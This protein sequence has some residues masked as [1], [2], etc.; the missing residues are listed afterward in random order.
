M[1]RPNACAQ[2]HLPACAKSHCVWGF[3]A[4]TQTLERL[5]RAQMD[6]G[7]HL[8]KLKAIRERQVKAIAS[9]KTCTGSIFKAEDALDAHKPLHLNITGREIDQGK[10]SRG[11]LA[12]TKQ[13][14]KVASTASACNVTRPSNVPVSAMTQNTAAD[15]RPHVTNAVAAAE[16]ATSQAKKLA[17]MAQRSDLSRSRSVTLPRNSRRLRTS[18]K[19]SRR[20]DGDAGQGSGVPCREPRGP[21][22]YVD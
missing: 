17:R 3:R 4:R 6:A 22:G 12:A 15:A 18:T 7:E 19:P 11:S 5:H 16:L 8:K 13:K 2:N 1:L 14:L 21:T 9:A 10:E 20:R